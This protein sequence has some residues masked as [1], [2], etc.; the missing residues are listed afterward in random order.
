MR[1]VLA[2]FN[3]VMVGVILGFFIVVVVPFVLGL[4]RLAA[5]PGSP[6]YFAVLLLGVVDVSLWHEL[7][8]IAAA[9]AVG[10]PGLRF[11]FSGRLLGFVMDYDYMQ[12]W[13]YVVVAL[14]PQTLT[15]LLLLAGVAVRGAAGGV[16]AVMG[17]GNLAGGVV[18]IV[19]AV[20]FAARHPRARRL[21]LLYDEDGRVVGGV[22]EEDDKLV[23]YQFGGAWRGT[24][25]GGG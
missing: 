11:R 14:A 1:V 20:Y 6:V 10:V 3:P 23:V 22:V 13:Q 8:H 5:L 15:L 21:L 12:L 18:D 19:N 17:L 16:L 24:A 7:L 4:L 2:R 25:G 9:G